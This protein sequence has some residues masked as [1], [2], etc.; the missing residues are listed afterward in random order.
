MR[1]RNRST[2]IIVAAYNEAKVIR[3]TL[4]P[5]LEQGYSVLVV[6]DGSSDGTWDVLQELPIFALRH[7]INLGQGAALQTGMMAALRMQADYLVHFD[8][9]GQHRVN[10][11]EV[12][13]EP[14]RQGQ[15]DV[16]LGSRF[17]RTEDEHAVPRKKRLLLKSAILVNMLLTGLWLSDAHN[18]FR[19]FTREAAQRIHLRQNRFAHASEILTQIRSHRLRYVER[20]TNI[21][22]S[23]YSRIK[24]QSMVNAFNIVV[25]LVL[26]KLLS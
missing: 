1:L 20:P 6:D 19:A 5:L 2:F 21:V 22:Y 25:D 7:P 15:A 18:G 23:E 4:T 9:D 11:I 3:A 24:G 12:L 8:A 10:D 13:L 14:L 26:A 17:L 16:A